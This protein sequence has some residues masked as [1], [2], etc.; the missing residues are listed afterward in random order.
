M[1]NYGKH[2]FL[3][4]YNPKK[5]YYIKAN[6][7]NLQMFLLVKKNSALWKSQQLQ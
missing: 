2:T 7:L 1:A 4:N 5:M 6:A 3:Q